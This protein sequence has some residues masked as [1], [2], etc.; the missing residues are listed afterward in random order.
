MLKKLKSPMWMANT[1]NQIDVERVI[2]AILSCTVQL[3][4]DIKK[5]QSSSDHWLKKFSI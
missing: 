2:T 4:L 5:M 3:I 1:D